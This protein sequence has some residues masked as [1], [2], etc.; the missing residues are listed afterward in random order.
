MARPRIDISGQTF[1]MLTVVE[2][3]AQVDKHGC[4]LWL[5]RCECG[6]VT[7]ARASDLKS[8]HKRSCGCMRRSDTA[9]LKGL[10]DCC[11]HRA[12][13]CEILTELVCSKKGKCSF[14]CV[15]EGRDFD[16]C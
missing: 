7:V 4:I 5:C 2:R 14:Y 13:H 8:G 1:G 15:K 10:P 9:G 3:T 16:D 11:W 6:G 12:S